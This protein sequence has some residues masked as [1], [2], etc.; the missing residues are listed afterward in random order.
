[1]IFLLIKSFRCHSVDSPEIF[2]D[3]VIVLLAILVLPH[4]EGPHLPP[5][6]DGETVR[7]VV[8]LQAPGVELGP[9]PPDGPAGHPGLGPLPPPLSAGVAV[10]AQPEWNPVV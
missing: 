10:A 9:A 4:L 1:M 2:T 3:I 8:G 7:V 5:A 6:P